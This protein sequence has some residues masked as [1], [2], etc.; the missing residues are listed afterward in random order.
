MLN[1]L[2]RFSL[3]ELEEKVLEFW[4]TNHVFAH[5]DEARKG[6][7]RFVFFEGPPTANGRP[8]IHHVISRAF[9]DVILRYQTMRGK[10]VL[11]RA[12]WDTHGLPVELEVEKALGLNSKKEIE[13]YGVVAFN[14]KCRESV[15]EYKDEWERLTERMGFWL[16]LAHPY[17]TY[18]NTY[19]ESV[20]WLL[21]QLWDKKLLYQ[22]HKVVPWCPRCGTALSSHELAQGY[23]ETTDTSVYLKFQVK[24]KDHTYLVSWTTTP[25]TLPG[26]VA[27]AVDERLDYV[28]AEHDGERLIYAKG[29]P[30]A[31]T[32]GAA[33]QR[34][35]KGTELV[36]LSYE[37]LYDIPAFRESDTAYRVYPAS[38]VTAEEGTGI[39][40]TAVMY[41]IDDYDLGVAA[42]LP[43]HHTVLPDGTFGDDVPELT[44]MF[45]KAK[46]TE[47]NILAH[48]K[49]RHA[50]LKEEPC[51]HEYPFCWRCDTP[52]IYYARDSWFIAMS[53]LRDELL[54]ANEHVQWVPP[55]IGSG[56]FGEWLR[57]VKDWALSRERYW[58][59]PLPVWECDRC[60][61]R[62]I[63][64]SFADL[65]ERC[66]GVRNTYAVM[67][68]TEAEHN[69][70]NVVSSLPEHKD[71]SA[72]TEQGRADAVAAGAKLKAERFI[73]D[74]IVAS[75]FLRTK[76]TA[77]LIARETGAAVV[78]D[79]RLRE[80]QLGDVEGQD[81]A[82]YHAHFAS[83]GERF[84][85]RIGDESETLRDVAVRVNGVFRDLE[86][87]YEGKRV[88]VVTHE[89]V[90]WMFEAVLSGW[91]EEQAVL[92]KAER[93]SA[94]VF[95]PGEYR[96]IAALALP[97]GQFGFADFHRPFVDEVAFPCP[98]DDAQGKRC[99]GTMRRVPDLIDV[100]FDSGAMPYAQWHYPFEH[101]E[102]VDGGEQFPADYICEAMDQTR[103]WFYTLLA[104]SVALG[105]GE[106]YRHVI[107]LGLVLDAYG[108]KMSKTRG[109]IVKPWDAFGQF[110]VDAVRWY[111]YT[112]NGPGEPKRFDEHELMK[113][114]RGPVMLLYNSFVFWNTYRAPRLVPGAPS[115]ILDRW[116]TARCAQVAATAT[117]ALDAYDVVLAARTIG[118]FI[119]DVSRWYIRRSRA[120][121]QNPASEDEHAQAYA[122]LSRILLCTARLIA[123]FM[124]LF[125]E[126]LYQ[127]LRAHVPQEHL[128]VHLDAW[129]APE[130]ADERL[131]T[132]M[133]QARALAQAGLAKREEAGIKV[134][135]PLPALIVRDAALRDESEL[136]DIVKDEVNV[137]EIRFDEHLEEDVALDTNITHELLEEGMLR[138]L[139][140]AVQGLRKDV[141][142]EPGDTVRLAVKSDADEVT[143]VVG[144]FKVDLERG[145]AAELVGTLDAFDGEK[146]IH[147]VDGDTTT[148][149]IAKR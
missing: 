3:P 103:G 132:H 91:G 125:A 101:R 42:H 138:E 11:R 16:D 140:R 84:Y 2:K 23:A 1:K 107:S 12:G 24:G 22:G 106:P 122:T 40:H 52:V 33:V 28:E 57:G 130:A 131:L 116:I 136:L 26:N 6:S 13:T 75:D 72:L 105:R 46:E 29:T 53:T 148:V 137:K 96:R 93:Q 88:L 76:E 114:V 145:A 32:L 113:V 133:K 112:V 67:R 62:E 55:A 21:K 139:L 104:L 48:L 87:R 77:E 100:W 49:E 64:G 118:E 79:E 102:L 95:E 123:P 9:K 142:C 7:E 61:T 129:P 5:V 119:E 17:I 15:W 82:A 65:S 81:A 39:V 143:H 134:R 108:R 120:R 115:H 60:G 68:H 128:S 86:R 89:Y 8:G 27:L 45:V 41:G 146:T 83:D 109:N 36:G 56:R 35:F 38:F 111:F 141:G 90:A 66:G 63:I 20:W 135:Q 19:M 78:F 124:P 43:Q 30:F 73:P 126:A 31:A 18:E 71:D 4:R 98:F 69:V 25:W 147:L 70:A 59:T 44:G 121:F 58:G 51:T 85:R 80:L 54:A 74:V 94:A 47:A 14:A 97:H 10:Y 117:A 110:G 92:K 149:R 127:S 37:P 50:L 99:G 34:E 144:K